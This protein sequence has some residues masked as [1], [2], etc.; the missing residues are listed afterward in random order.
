MI[1]FYISFY[2][3]PMNTR[4]IRA[5]AI[6]VEGINYTTNPEERKWTYEATCSSLFKMALQPR[7]S[8]NLSDAIHIYTLCEKPI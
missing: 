5:S 3:T 4:N 7:C 1:T 8:A 6:C 2:G